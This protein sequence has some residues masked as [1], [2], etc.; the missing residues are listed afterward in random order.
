VN[1]RIAGLVKTLTGLRQAARTESL[2]ALAARVLEE[3]PFVA[4]CAAAY[5]GEQTVANLHKVARLAAEAGETRGETVGGFVRRVAGDVG[6]GV[7]EGE[8]PL[9]EDRT[10]AVRLLTVHK[11][12][13]LEYK[14]VILPNLSATV[15]G[16]AHRPAAFRL[17]WAEGRAGHRLVKRKWSDLAMAFMDIDERRREKEEAIRLFYVAATRATGAC[18]FSGRGEILRGIVYGHVI[19]SI[20]T[21]VGAPP[22]RP[23]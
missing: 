5:H 11:A 21:H 17:D 7:E 15:R 22:N 14:V 16:S 4:A 18:D 6:R 23:R 1:S 10:E 9:G 12:K 19:G 8:N 20:P 2:G 3:T 13:G